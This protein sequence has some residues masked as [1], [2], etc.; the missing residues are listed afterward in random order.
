MK[1][2]NILILGQTEQD[3]QPILFALK[4]YGFEVSFQFVRKINELFEVLEK[5]PIDAVVSSPNMAN[6]NA[7][8]ALQILKENK[9]EAPFLV[10]SDRN[11][12][13]MIVSLLKAGAESYLLKSNVHCLGRLVE[14]VLEQANKRLLEKNALHRVEEE[15]VEREKMLAVVSHDLKNPLGAIKLNIQ[16][17]Q[18]QLA[19]PDLS[20]REQKIA[21][22]IERIYRAAI[23]M[24]NLIHDILDCSKIDAGRYK[25]EK[26]PNK[27]NDLMTTTVELFQPVALQ[28]NI[29]LHS[30]Y[31]KDTGVLEFDFE[32]IMQVLANLVGN[33]IK[34]TAEGGTIWIRAESQR[35]RFF[36][37]VEDTGAGIPTE[38]L[39]YVFDRFWQ[40][41]KT[42]HEGTGLGLSIAKGVVEAHGGE[43]WVESEL[44]KGTRFS[45]YIPVRRKNED[46]ENSSAEA[47]LKKSILLIDDDEDIRE[48][49]QR[50]LVEEGYNVQTA[51]DGEKGIELLQ[52]LEP[53]PHLVILDGR[54]PKLNGRDFIAR[55]KTLGSAKA[56]VPV[57]MTSAEAFNPQEAMELGIKKFIQKPPHL[58][59][60]LESVAKFIA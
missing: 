10:L 52:K 18:R 60:L 57:I 44:G 34:F 40:A 58:N 36:V 47:K 9:V 43:I 17:I 41:N 11:D 22:Q 7:L 32:R 55:K 38:E 31:P 50:A 53:S 30:I 46:A 12:E 1:K 13:E 48:V 20:A 25:V 39:P 21:Q 45:F 56:L 59:E 42:N 27:L 6:F 54:L 28:K 8:N 49:L 5:G 14:K 19:S 37:Q 23:R 35:D 16:M 2:I 33:A 4:D 51:E 3:T 26:K 15:I 24:E 29:Q